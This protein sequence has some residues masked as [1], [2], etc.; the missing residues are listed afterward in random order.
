M[1]FPTIDKINKSSCNL[2]IKLKNI[3]KYQSLVRLE[4]LFDKSF[5]YEIITWT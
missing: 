2:N 5:T 3:S 1:D 4:E